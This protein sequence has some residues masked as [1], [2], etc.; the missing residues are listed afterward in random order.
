MTVG[1]AKRVSAAAILR[2]GA[3][4]LHRPQRIPLDRKCDPAGWAKPGKPTI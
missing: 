4:W 1:E 3:A 2:A